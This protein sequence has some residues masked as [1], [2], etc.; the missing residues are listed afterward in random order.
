VSP[1]LREAIVVAGEIAWQ[2][3][4]N[5]AAGA[6]YDE[7]RETHARLVA[8]LERTTGLSANASPELRLLVEAMWRVAAASFS[9]RYGLPYY[10]RREALRQLRGCLVVYLAAVAA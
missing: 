5:L 7:R 1:A 8:T 6:R 9:N 2:P 4:A 3:F 10:E